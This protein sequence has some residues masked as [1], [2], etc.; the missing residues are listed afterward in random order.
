[1]GGRGSGR[2]Y[3][4][5]KKDTVESCRRLD[6]RKLNRHGVLKPD[7][8]CNWGWW[9]K[10]GNVISDINIYSHEEAVRIT[11]TINPNTDNAEKIDYCIPIDYTKCSYGG[12]RPWF[13][14]PGEN[15]GKRV[16]ILYLSDRR[17]LCRHC[18]NLTY[19]CQQENDYMRL[20][21]K[22]QKI[23]VRLGGSGSTAEPFP[24]KPRNMHRKTYDRLRRASLNAQ[25]ASL[26]AASKHFDLVF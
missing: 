22:A 25:Y 1:M 3:Q 21:T 20:L 2:L 5:D 18:Q 6:V 4:W 26:H 11:Y 14:C 24:P 7:C 9:D 13:I 8:Y 12:K 19:A 10:D 17:F 23:R 15:C 16:A